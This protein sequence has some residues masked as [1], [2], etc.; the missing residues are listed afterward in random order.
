MFVF[1]FLLKMVPKFVVI[2]NDWNGNMS[3]CSYDIICMADR[4]SS[5]A[6]NRNHMTEFAYLS[7]SENTVGFFDFRLRITG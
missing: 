5:R 7:K 3:V 2:S 1:Q 4:E 6:M